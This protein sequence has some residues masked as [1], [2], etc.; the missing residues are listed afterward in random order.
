[1]PKEWL[2]FI[3]RERGW[4]LPLVAEVLHSRRLG[5]FLSLLSQK[6]TGK[7]YAWHTLAEEMFQS[8]QRD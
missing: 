7:H 4:G 1:M 6:S 8:A 2:H 5:I 3:K